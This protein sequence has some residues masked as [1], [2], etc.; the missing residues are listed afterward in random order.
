MKRGQLGWLFGAFVLGGLLASCG[1]ADPDIF[2]AG[3]GGA[4]TSGSSSSSG[5]IASG[6]ASFGGGI[7]SGGV[8][9]TGGGVASGGVASGGNSAGGAS[10]GGASGS[11]GGGAATFMQVRAVIQTLKCVNC[12]M[13]LFADNAGLYGRLT[14]AL[15]GQKCGTSLLVNKANLSDSLL[16]RILTSQTT[17]SSGMVNRMPNGCGTGGSSLPCATDAQVKTIQDWIA[18]GAVEN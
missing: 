6:G 7:A 10:T 3:V 13:T 4:G 12:H 14:T 5:G 8:T 2:N 15:G 17:C 18:A 16:P 1:S 9:A 11:G